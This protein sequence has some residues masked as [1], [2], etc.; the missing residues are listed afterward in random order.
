MALT[1]NF[2]VPGKAPVDALSFGFDFSQWL[3]VSPLGVIDTIVSA[4]ITA[5][6]SGLAIGPATING[7]VAGAVITGGVDG[8]TY[9]ISC[10]ITTA[11]G[12]VAQSQEQLPVAENAR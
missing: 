1:T 4:V 8:V 5:S 9:L 3:E 11:T 6:P 7:S 12:Q 2:F 10:V